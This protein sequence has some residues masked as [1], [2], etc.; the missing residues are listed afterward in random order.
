[1]LE[2]YIKY[3]DEKFEKEK[4][5]DGT[6]IYKNSAGEAIIEIYRKLNIN[7]IV[8]LEKELNLMSTTYKRGEQTFPEW[9][10]KF[11]LEAN[12]LNVYFSAFSLY[13]KQTINRTNTQLHSPFELRDVNGM[14]PKRIENN[15]FGIGNFSYNATH[16]YAD[17][18]GKI[19]IYENFHDLYLHG[20]NR[21]LLGAKV[22]LIVEYNSL[23]EFLIT[24]T[25]RLDQLYQVKPWQRTRRIIETVPSI[26]K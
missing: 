12:G 24:E 17:E 2:E 21:A 15:L 6:T 1:M 8:K 10:I 18:L 14:R 4:L 26:K 5:K 7:E 9:Y 23:S 16:I 3:L 13:G 20:T 19:Y 25:E 11:F 22:K